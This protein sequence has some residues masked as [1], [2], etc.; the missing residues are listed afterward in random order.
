VGIVN[1]THVVAVTRSETT[2]LGV[3]AGAL[4]L[5][6]VRNKAPAMPGSKSFEDSTTSPA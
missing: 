4:R 2:H 5:A 6:N 3:K 1:K